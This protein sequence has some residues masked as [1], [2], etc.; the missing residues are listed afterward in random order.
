[1]TQ[2]NLTIVTKTLAMAM[3]FHEHDENLHIANEQDIHT[4]SKTCEESGDGLDSGSLIISFIS[5]H[6]LRY[7]KWA[8]RKK[9]KKEKKTTTT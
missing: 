3:T 8:S 7:E 1:M 6:I 4:S 2:F 5:D 9:E